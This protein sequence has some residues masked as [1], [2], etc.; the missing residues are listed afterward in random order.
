MPSRIDNY[1]MKDGLTPLG[2]RY[3]N[4]VWEDIDIRIAELEQL[5]MSWDAAISEVSN[6]GVVRINEAITGPL[7]TVNAAII[8][9]QDNLKTLPAF[10]G[11]ADLDIAMSALQ[12]TVNGQ[13]SALETTINGRLS[14]LQTTINGQLSTLE[15]TINGRMSALESLIYAGL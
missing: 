14:A 1:R 9:M 7:E 10:V 11:E 12:T 4:P 6:F 13:L 5:H 8:L 3:F 2:E 15:S